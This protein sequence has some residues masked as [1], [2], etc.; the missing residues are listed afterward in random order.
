LLF[1]IP[2]CVPRELDFITD[3]VVKSSVSALVQSIGMMSGALEVLTLR[4]PPPDVIAAEIVEEPKTALA[5]FVAD[6]G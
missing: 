1:R 2:N 4:I 5:E 6:R 3:A